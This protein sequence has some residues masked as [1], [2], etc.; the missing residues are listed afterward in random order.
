M[1]SD[2]QRKWL[3]VHFL[4]RLFLS[5][6]GLYAKASIIPWLVAPSG[7]S[8]SGGMSVMPSRDGAA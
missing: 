1:T 6:T 3:D 2:C 8:F 5:L 7:C 4:L